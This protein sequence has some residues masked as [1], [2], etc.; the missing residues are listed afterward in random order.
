MLNCYCSFHPRMRITMICNDGFLCKDKL[1]CSTW[2]DDSIRA[3]VTAILVLEWLIRS[4]SMTDITRI[5]P[6]Y[7]IIHSKLS[8]VCLWNKVLLLALVFC[9]WN[10]DYCSCI[11]RIKNFF[12]NYW[13]CIKLWYKVKLII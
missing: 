3:K 10:N 1:V 13:L 6:N 8:C 7:S 5:F 4:N 12:W 2:L 9:T 11:S